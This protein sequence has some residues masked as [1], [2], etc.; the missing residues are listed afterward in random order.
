M[1]LKP[2]PPLEID[3]L[4][5]GSGEADETWQQ[6]VASPEGTAAW[7][8]AVA[9]RQRLDRWAVLLQGHHWLA[10]ATL[11]A[12]RA[13]RAQRALTG[14]A[15]FQIQPSPLAAM[16][17]PRPARQ[18]ELPWGRQEVVEV[19]IGEEL[20]LTSDTE[21]VVV[22]YQYS[23]RSGV[24]TSSW[25]ME[26]GDAPVLLVAVQGGSEQVRSID[27]ALSSGL[28]MALLVL[29]EPTGESH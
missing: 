10:A 24:L 12:R 13:L 8:A 1:P 7:R 16:L 5:L 21:H 9:R 3:A 2:P 25:R 4:V 23:T 20:R 6:L 27:E 19:A 14:G 22:F 18:V 28:S 11:R 29:I 17:T 26:A 15:R